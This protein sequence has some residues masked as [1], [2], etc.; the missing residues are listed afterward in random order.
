MSDVVAPVTD[1][2]Y[3]MLVDAGI[4]NPAS[5]TSGFR[6]YVGRMP[7]KPDTAVAISLTGEFQPD[8]KWR[9][10]QPTLQFL[11]RA[12]ATGY[13]TAQAKI[14]E[15]K[16]YLVGRPAFQMGGTKY[17]G[18][19]AQGGIAFLEYDESNRPTFWFNIRVVREPINAKDNRRPMSQLS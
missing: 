18:I 3:D 4:M 16:D 6:G 7:D 9:L 1:D 11:V 12:G 14:Q 19:Y 15:I 5:A 17:V 8:P 13:A 10:D 2:I